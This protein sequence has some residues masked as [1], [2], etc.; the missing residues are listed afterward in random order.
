ML[1]DKIKFIQQ[2]YEKKFKVEKLIQVLEKFSL[3]GGFYSTEPKNDAGQI[4]DNKATSSRPKQ[5]H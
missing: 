1:T 3:S 5:Q 2:K 4:T